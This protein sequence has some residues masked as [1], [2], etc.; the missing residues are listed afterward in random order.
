MWVIP[1]V[2][3]Q[4]VLGVVGVGGVGGVGDVDLVYVGLPDA[5][6]KHVLTVTTPLQNHRPV[7]DKSRE[8]G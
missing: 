5:A 3:S 2:N 7:H 6:S 4:L 1:I 8:A